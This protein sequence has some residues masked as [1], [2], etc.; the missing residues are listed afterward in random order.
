MPQFFIN[1]DLESDERFD[2]A[3]FLEFNVDNYDVLN[4]RFLNDLDKT[5][6]ASG[7][8]EVRVEEDRPDLLSNSIY[9][10]TQLWWIVLYFNNLLSVDE[11]KSGNM[12]QFPTVPAV[13]NKFFNLKALEVQND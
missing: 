7:E 12:L 2:L 5:V 10:S 9:N 13:E 8:F 4:S 11:Y 6:P 1:T 3:K